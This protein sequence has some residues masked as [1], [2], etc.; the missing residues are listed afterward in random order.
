[1]R[2]N[3]IESKE[4]Y[5]GKILDL[6]QDTILLENGSEA[7]REVVRHKKGACI[8][9]YDDDFAYLAE[10]YRHPI[11]KPVLEIAAGICE[12]HEN[13]VSTAKRELKEELNALC[14]E[15]V[16][17]G[18]YYSSPGFCDEIIY[19]YAAKVTGFEKGTQDEDEF[20]TTRKI[21]LE[22]FYRMIDTGE[23][24]DGKTI[25]AVCKFRCRQKTEQTR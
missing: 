22:T 25:A 24:K 13:P 10:Q 14:G 12:E 20:V 3:T 17:L 11:G 6:Y 7:K 15:P 8:F 18:E 16:F 4:I 9:D 1:M 21:P 5:K 19:M 23:I 2:P